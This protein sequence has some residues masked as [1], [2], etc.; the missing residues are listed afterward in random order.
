M[1]M[2]NWGSMGDYG[3]G[4]LWNQAPWLNNQDLF[5]VKDD[6]SAVFGKHFVKAGVLL[7]YNKKNEEVNN[8]SQESVQVNGVRGILGPNGYQPGTAGTGNIIANWL[9]RGHGLE[10]DRAPDQPE[11][12][13]ALEGL[14]GVHRGHLQGELAA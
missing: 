11:R 7:S 1:P 8:T 9:L 12:A 10:H 5:V 3:G 4:V 14:R 13:A 2:A 6:Y